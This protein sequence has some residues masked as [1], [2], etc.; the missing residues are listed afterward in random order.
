M[1]IVHDYTQNSKKFSKDQINSKIVFIVWNNHG[2]RAEGIS[3]YLGACLYFLYTSRIRH[4]IL[5]VKTLSILRKEKPKMVICQNPPINCAL[6]ALLYR[7][8]FGRKAKPIIL[9]DAHRGSFQRP[10]SQIKFLTRF[11]LRRANWIIVE[12]TEVQNLVFKTYHVNPLVLED[13]IPIFNKSTPNAELMRK[14]W[15]NDSDNPLTTNV[16]VINPFTWDSPLEEILEAAAELHGKVRFFF[17]GE[18]KGKGKLVKRTD[19][20]ILTGFLPRIEYESLLKYVDII[21]DL[22]SDEGRMQAGGYE[23]IAAEKA[24]IVSDNPPLRRY[25]NKGTIYV[26]NSSREIIEAIKKAVEKKEQ[27]EKEM[28]ELSSEKQCEWEEKITRNILNQIKF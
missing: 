19:N 4:P 9:V 13:P 15:Y 25:F 18:L 12:N 22:T 24:L 5:F 6:V 3:K 2:I 28:R 17:T 26:F 1:L 20:V 11:V 27:L 7:Y 10:W 23:A 8:L 21:I 16:A 14:K